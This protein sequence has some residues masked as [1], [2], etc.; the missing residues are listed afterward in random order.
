MELAALIAGGAVLA[1]VPA[2]KPPAPIPQSTTIAAAPVKVDI[3]SEP[4]TML[5][6]LER[7][8]LDLILKIDLNAATARELE[9]VPGVGP[10]TAET[11]VKYRAENGPFRSVDELDNVPGFGPSTVEKIRPH[12]RIAAE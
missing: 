11:I 3:K 1:F 10:K 7:E 12:V 8:R 4:V 2:K 9:N 5:T 6:D